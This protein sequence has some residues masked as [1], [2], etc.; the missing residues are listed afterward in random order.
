V[1]DEQ[2]RLQ[3]YFG[4]AQSFRNYL[5]VVTLVETVVLATYRPVDRLHKD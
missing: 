2:L 1:S 5:A 4:R 3:K